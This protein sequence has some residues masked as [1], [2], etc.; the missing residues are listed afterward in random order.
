MNRHLTI[1]FFYDSFKKISLF[2]HL[3]TFIFKKHLPP[4]ET[5]VSKYRM[6]ELPSSQQ[7]TTASLIKAS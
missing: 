3:F 5:K 2:C 1:S 4:I 7:K 6:L